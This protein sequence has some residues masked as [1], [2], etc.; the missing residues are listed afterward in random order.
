MYLNKLLIKDFGKFNNKEIGLKP[1]IN[2]I[3]GQKASGKT[4]IKEFITAML[5]GF[6]SCSFNDDDNYKYETYKPADRGYSGKAYIKNGDDTY[7]VER[8]FTR[9]SSRTSVL[10]IGTGRELKVSGGSLNGKL[11]DLSK[12]DFTNCLCIDDNDGVYTEYIKKDL[13]NI[14]ST[15]TVLIDKDKSIETLK[16][17][18]EAFDISAI[19]KNTASTPAVPRES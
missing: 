16:A 17:K 19:D 12:D 13:K 3:Q 2:V 4:T 5:Y 10:D 18:R 8:S 9:K 11:F 6:S 14:V 1:G 7:F 15:G